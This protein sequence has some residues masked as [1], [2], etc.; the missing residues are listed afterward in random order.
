MKRRIRAII[1]EDEENLRHDLRRRLASLWPELVICGEA[2]DGI[3]AVNLIEEL[4]PDVAFLDIKMPGVSG[5]DVARHAAGKC[6]TV[7]I[8]AY[9]KYAVDAFENE[10]VDYLLKPIADER[11]EKMIDRLKNKLASPATYLAGMSTL[12]ERIDPRILRQPEYLQWIRVPYR[13]GIRL[14]SVQEIYYFKATDKYT[15]VRTKEA[16][17][18]IRKAIRD[19]VDE[20]DPRRFWRIHR[21]TIVNIENIINVERSHTG[22]YH[23]RFLDLQEHL[24]VSRAYTHLFKTM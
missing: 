20:L 24:T 16:E 2:E 21:A 17:F 12:L 7:F 9:D 23:I 18:L 11:L 8:T 3:A 19:L 14:V 22:S 4:A 6:L 13:D 15:A 5:I 10:A 1:V